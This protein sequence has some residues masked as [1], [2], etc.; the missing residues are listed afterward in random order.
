MNA[1]TLL[2]RASERCS[3]HRQVPGFCNDCAMDELQEM[4]L[5]ENPELSRGGAHDLAW[6]WVA[7]VDEAAY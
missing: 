1:D 5:E 2:Q 6:E 4:L 3:Q 7:R